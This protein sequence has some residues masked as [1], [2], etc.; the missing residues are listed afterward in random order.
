MSRYICTRQD[1]TTQTTTAPTLTSIRRQ[2][3]YSA[4]TESKE[5]N[6][7][8]WVPAF[9][10]MTEKARERA[11]ASKRQRAASKTKPQA[12]RRPRDAA[13]EPDTLSPCGP[14]V[15]A[16]QKVDQGVS[17][18]AATLTTPLFATLRRVPRRGWHLGA[19]FFAYF[20]WR[21]KESE[22]LPG[23]PRRSLPTGE[24]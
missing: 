6:E 17:R 9:A 4:R 24:R 14:A 11:N 21:A 8:H 22:R 1:Q 13:G 23:R 16:A 20:L 15:G 12:S 3:G 10:G 7:S 19:G 18:S 2:S 5:R